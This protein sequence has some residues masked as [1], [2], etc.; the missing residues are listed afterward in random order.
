MSLGS[1]FP[2]WWLVDSLS[3][4]LDA[5]E[6]EAVRGDLMESGEGAGLAA[7]NVLGLVMRR[8]IALWKGWQPWLA[9][10]CFVVPLGMLISL[11][12]RRLADGNAIDVWFY[13][14]NWDWHLVGYAGFWNEFFQ[15]V[16]G[17]IMSFGALVCWSWTCGFV[18]TFVSGRTIWFNGALFCVVLLLGE[19]LGA[20]RHVG[21][22]LLLTRAR[23]FH[24]NSAVFAIRFYRLTF[25]LIVQAVLV[26][27]PSLWGMRQ[28]LQLRKLSPVLNAFLWLFA[29]ATV[30]TLVTENSV[31]WQFR[32]W[33]M[34]PLRFPRL[35]SLLPFAMLGP[36]AYV[37]AAA[38]W[39]SSPRR[40]GISIDDQ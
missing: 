25:P 40:S 13:A 15:I 35:P 10:F 20:P 32:V 6:R 31:W 12:S 30:L 36:M 14:N 2:S 1:M 28:S 8:Q 27:L 24:N 39:K 7:W 38:R 23:D 5:S 21:Q 18:I 19:F 11:A 4:M 17:V 33:T 37:L 16:P 34:L 29:L 9:L 26:V 22:L 3:R